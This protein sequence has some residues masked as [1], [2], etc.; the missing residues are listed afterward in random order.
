MTDQRCLQLVLSSAG[1]NERTKEERKKKGDE[2]QLW[3]QLYF[4]SARRDGSTYGSSSSSFPS[5]AALTDFFKPEKREK[6]A[7]FEPS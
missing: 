6:S 4:P 2:R 3:L 7:T 1:E 5:L